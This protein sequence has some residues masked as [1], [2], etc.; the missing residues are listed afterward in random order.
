MERLSEDNENVSLNF[1]D[2]EHVLLTFNPK[3]M[4]KRLPGCPPEHD[5]RLVHA[6]VLE[7]P[8]GKVVREADWYLHDHRRYLWPLGPGKVLLRR[9]N[10][11]YS[12]DAN[13]RETLLLSLPRDLLWVS[14]TPDGSQIVVETAKDANAVAVKE[15]KPNS[16][17]APG[18][19]EPKYLIEFLDAKTLAPQ[20]AIPAKELVKL[21][22]SSMGYVDL[23][24][25]NHLWLIRFGPTPGQ[26]HN[27]A[28]A[29]SQT[30]PSVVYSSD[31]V[32]LIGRCPSA[33]CDYSV[34][35]FTVTGHRLWRQHWNQYRGFPAVARSEDSSR[36]GI[37]TLRVAAPASSAV[38]PDDDAAG[39]PDDAV[40]Q[41]GF[42]QDIQIFETASGNPV[43]SVQASPA[44]LSG[45]NFSL[46]PDGR[47]LAA[48]HGASL[49]LFDLPQM[50]EEERAKYA[51]LKTDVPGLY[52]LAST[53]DSG[54]SRDAD[55][56]AGN[57]SEEPPQGSEVASAKATAG[58][59]D[60]TNSGDAGEA[61]RQAS[62]AEAGNV[63]GASAGNAASGRKAEDPNELVATFK[64][65]TK[66]VVVDVVVTD[67]KG[68]PV[69]GL[70]EQDFQLAEDGKAQEVHSFKEFT[71]AEEQAPT[72]PLVG[73]P[74]R[75]PPNVFSNET[76]A[77]DPGSVTLVL[78]D[79]LNTPTAD[80]EYA[81]QQLIKFLETKPKNSQFALC[82]LSA[83]A[84]PLRLI[85]G[86]TL[87]ENQLLAAIRGKKGARHAV[88]WQAAASGTEAA[89]STV[90]GL[91]QA[92]P[93]SGFQGLLQV[94]QG[95]QAEQQGT[96]T[97]E[98]AGVTVDSLM[99]LARY[100]SGIP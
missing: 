89:V 88:R 51:A 60:A 49:E 8:S 3:K 33:V 73:T 28:R 80:Q 55:S 20:R 74:T 59:Q 79:L 61:N 70:R 53:P 12:V 85:Q 68:H 31:N 24:R 75:L 11:L 35:A 18:K 87:D 56:M 45:Q 97:D 1:V 96:D 16:S 76:H 98:R 86:F 6:A 99:L 48:L 29:R 46:S 2:A 10:S 63:P 25:K 21:E 94:L 39:E 43:L 22:E 9:L 4:V 67:A 5:D 19:P 83:G 17:K 81:R 38:E 37:S 100:L 95:M 41:D 92:G 71:S 27:V 69:K 65:S 84:S 36:F 90:G 32:L 44:V 62:V 91:A 7:V 34:T 50:S 14:V 26:R 78:L 77:P 57:G 66:A 13:L 40:R 93:T 54:S 47:R 15:S 30:V 58:K 23:L 42:R 72:V 52:T 82:T 64:V